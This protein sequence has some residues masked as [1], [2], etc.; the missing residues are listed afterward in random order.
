M[1][2][3]LVLASAIVLAAAAPSDSVFTLYRNS[4]LNAAM[5]MHV[6][7]FDAD[8]GTSYNQENCWTA[9]KLFQGQSG[10]TVTFW[11]EKGRYHE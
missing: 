11:C 1:M 5:R 8:Q 7:T 4:A 9:Q 3:H 10:V 6:S 2:P